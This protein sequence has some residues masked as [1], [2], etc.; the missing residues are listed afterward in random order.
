MDGE[1]LDK[2]LALRQD[3]YSRARIQALIKQGEVLLIRVPNRNKIKDPSY[4]VKQDD[5]IIISFPKLKETDIKPQN[6]PLDVLHE[7]DSLIVI[8]KP[9]GLVVHPAPG[10][11]DGTLVNALLAHC[12]DSLS[13]IGGEK[14]PGIVH[15]LDKD[16]SGVM[17]AAKTDAAHHSLSEQF[18]A[19]GADGRMKRAYEALVWGRP[20]PASGRIEA[21]IARHPHNRIKMHVTKHESARHAA[22]RYTVLES[23]ANGAGAGGAGAGAGS[24]GAKNAAIISSVRCE[25]ETGRTHQIR[26]HM[27]HHGHVVIGDKVYGAGQ[28]S[29]LNKLPEPVAAAILALGRQAL[30]AVLLGFEHPETG[31]AMAFSAPLPADMTALKTALKEQFYS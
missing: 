28:A 18:A 20:L 29:R 31:E 26:V 19:H 4:R 8:N 27:A 1:R 10:N 16:T 22:T 24:A 9:A 6:I 21:A 12:G 23:W 13:G 3:G 2:M 5:E 14:R 15:R 7:D 30:H 25:L 17:V 11:L